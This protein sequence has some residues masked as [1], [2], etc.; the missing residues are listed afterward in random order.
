MQVKIGS[1]QVKLTGLIV[2]LMFLIIMLRTFALE[3]AK[4]YVSDIM[5][6]NLISGGVSV[7]LS[8]VGAYVL[9]RLFI[10]KPLNELRALAEAFKANDFTKRTHLRT[11]DEF[12][13]LGES[14][15]ELAVKIEGLMG[16]IEHSSRTIL[17]QSQDVKRASAE[18]E[19]TSAQVMAS[20]QEMASG[21]EQMQHEISAIVE[22]ANAMA[23]A[24]TQ[25]AAHAQTIRAATGDVV[26]LVDR[27]GESATV[28]TRH[29]ED[30]KVQAGEMDE[31]IR[32]LLLKSGEVEEITEMINGLAEQTGLLA[33]NASIEA[34]RAGEHGRGFGVVA[35][36]VKKL[37]AQSRE[38]A[39]SVRALI[40]DVQEQVG[41]IS[42]GMQ[43][44]RATVERMSGLVSETEQA[45]AGIRA[46]TLTMQGRIEEIGESTHALAT[47]NSE[48]LD[49][50]TNIAGVIEELTAGIN[51]VSTS[52]TQQ[53][54]MMQQMIG[55][56]G[57]LR[58]V[59]GDL[60]ETMSGLRR[61]SAGAPAA[62]A[63]AAAKRT[64]KPAMA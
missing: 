59:A 22:T 17:E 54:A 26:G 6:T 60:D 14:Y 34:A 27:A 39:E 63:A 3:F 31:Q 23:A 28:T 2:V 20:M 46:S 36:E 37:A 49:S 18:S 50:T 16:Q 35:G 10:K 53:N 12:Q 56:A 15:N 41:R 47:G 19:Q 45:V 1:L 42:A 30:V 52:A 9:I 44:N 8:A 11:R 51:Q 32:L 43:D 5:W 24:S 25:A 4:N 29:A 64:G 7:L 13:Q 33:L 57:A 55:L 62:A 21:S 38:R 58:D 40:V 48:V 61:G